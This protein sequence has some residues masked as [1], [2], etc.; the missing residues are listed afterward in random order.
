MASCTWSGVSPTTFTSNIGG[1]K[2]SLVRLAVGWRKR[3]FFHLVQTCNNTPMLL[4]VQQGKRVQRAL[5]LLEPLV[6]AN[7]WQPLSACRRAEVVVETWRCS[8][9]TAVTPMWLWI[10]WLCFHTQASPEQYLCGP[11]SH[12]WRG[13]RENYQTGLG[14]QGWWCMDRPPSHCPTL[15]VGSLPGGYVTEI[16]QAWQ[17]VSIW[18]T[19]SVCFNWAH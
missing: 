16:Q 12:W 3:F 10:S 19:R 1:L 6:R 15:S 13:G 18:C 9:R 14:V 8:K 17:K 7:T 11:K 4:K 5:C 2:R